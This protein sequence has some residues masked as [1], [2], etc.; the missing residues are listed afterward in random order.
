MDFRLGLLFSM[1]VIVLAYSGFYIFRSDELDKLDEEMSLDISD[2][3]NDF[4][5]KIKKIYKPIF[6]AELKARN[7]EVINCAIFNLSHPETKKIYS[8]IGVDL[9]NQDSILELKFYHENVL[10][11]IFRDKKI[12]FE[13]DGNFSFSQVLDEIGL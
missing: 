5:I 3:E 6:L 10:E 9:K 12:S 7:I 2:Q 13:L 8:N 11:V 1:G 4:L